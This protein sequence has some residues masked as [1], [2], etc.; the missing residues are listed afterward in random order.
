MLIGGSFGPRS[1]T[2]APRKGQRR[3]CSAGVSLLLG[4]KCVMVLSVYILCTGQLRRVDT[5][6][7]VNVR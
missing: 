6:V 2:S 7:D 1:P 3:V 4:Q 5:F